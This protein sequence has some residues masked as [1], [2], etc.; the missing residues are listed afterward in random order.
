MNTDQ[1]IAR[2]KLTNPW[3]YFLAT[4][5]WS[6]IFW[7]IA[8][9]MGVS[10]E[11]GEAVGVILVLLA[12]SGPMV[13][14]ITFVYFSLN[15]E[16]Q[17]DYWKRIINFKLISAKWYL[18]IFLLIPIVS[19][20]A[21]LLGGFWDKLTLSI[22][23][24]KLSMTI[25]SIP[26]VPFLEELGWRGYALDR[27]QERY[28]ALVSSLILGS[29]WGFWHLPVFFL[30]GSI[31]NLMPVGSLMFWMYLL[32]L[33]PLS[34]CMT[35]IYNNTGRSTLSAILFHIMLEIVANLGLVLWYKQQIIYNVLLISL[36]TVG[37]TIIFGAKTL[38][39]K[40]IES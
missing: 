39:R 25:L 28:S 15:R 37:I 12:I 6:W 18:V 20:L 31:Y 11:S 14:G 22:V 26:L 19:V 5:A 36:V 24:P 16:G 30:N 10:A 33:I 8:Y 29:L 38:V 13:I 2:P 27:L 9:L 17:K 1:Y 40:K 34:V 32:H 35:W 23:L 21:A 3:V 4:F 7:G